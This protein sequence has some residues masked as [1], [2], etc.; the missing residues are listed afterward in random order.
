ERSRVDLPGNRAGSSNETGVSLIRVSESDGPKLGAEEPRPSI[1]SIEHSPNPNDL[2]GAYNT[3]R[4]ETPQ[5]GE[6][7]VKKVGVPVEERGVEEVGVP[8]EKGGDREPKDGQL[9]NEGKYGQEVHED[10]KLPD[11]KKR[12]IFKPVQI[13]EEK[14]EKIIKR[15]QDYATTEILKNQSTSRIAR[16]IN[17]IISI[18]NSTI[19]INQGKLGENKL[20]ELVNEK[21]RFYFKKDPT[22]PSG[23]GSSPGIV[24]DDLNCDELNFPISSLEKIILGL[25]Y[26]V[27]HPLS[28]EEES[29]SSQ[30]SG[31]YERASDVFPN[32]VP[33][34]DRASDVSSDIDDLEERY[35]QITPSETN[36]SQKDL[37]KI[38]D[39]EMKHYLATK[40]AK[41]YDDV[42]IA[43]RIYAISSNI[44]ELIIKNG[45]KLAKSELE[46]AIDSKIEIFFRNN[47]LKYW[48]KSKGSYHKKFIAPLK[49]I[50]LR[51]YMPEQEINDF[52]LDEANS[53]GED[54]DSEDDRLQK[55]I[56]MSLEASP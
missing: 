8:E 28:D 31:G 17:D 16:Q 18:I 56:A 7:K 20:Q 55:A 23:A 22:K 25:Y 53:S 47:I 11:T 10:F 12:K 6:P 46:Y 30:T 13:A 32:I 50:I 27:A 34:G 26:E 41:M 49:Q 39:E 2:R 35:D 52:G 5:S 48:T 44:D 33:G 24:S 19:D 14:L 3:L 1:D 29:V 45:G 43:A 21:I 36:I 54:S 15:M 4:S 51:Q 42:F 9:L 38:V 40:I 37:K